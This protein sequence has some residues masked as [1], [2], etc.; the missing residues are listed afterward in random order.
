[1]ALMSPHCTRITSD[2]CFDMIITVS[3]PF[4]MPTIIFPEFYLVVFQFFIVFVLSPY[5]NDVIY[6]FM[7]CSATSGHSLNIC[8]LS[9]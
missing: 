2:E 8:P 5:S 6:V 7:S 3:I 9:S 1:M 4:E